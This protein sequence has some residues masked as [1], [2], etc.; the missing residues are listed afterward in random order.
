MLLDLR[1]SRDRDIGS[2]FSGYGTADPVDEG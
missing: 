2:W 1:I